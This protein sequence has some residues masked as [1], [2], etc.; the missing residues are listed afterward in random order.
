MGGNILC[1]LRIELSVEVEPLEIQ[2]ELLGKLG[3]LFR[4]DLGEEV[5]EYISRTLE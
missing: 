1:E 4:E 3:E 5:P 2:L